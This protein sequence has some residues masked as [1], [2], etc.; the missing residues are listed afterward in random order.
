MTQKNIFS[1]F[2][3]ILSCMFSQAY[4]QTVE[5]LSLSKF[6]TEKPPKSI[7][8]KL[9]EPLEISEDVIFQAGVIMQGDLYNVVSPKRLKRDA[10]FSFKPI[11][12]QG[13]DGKKYK[14][15]SNIVASYTEPLNKGELAKNAALGVGNFFV[16]GLSMGVAAVS[17]AVKNQEG[18]R[19][20]SSAVSVYES[21]PLSYAEKGQDISIDVNQ[22][23]YLKFSSKN[24]KGD[25]NV[26]S[27]S[28]DEVKGQNY[29]YNIIEKE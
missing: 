24:K 12:Y 6:S 19:I 10:D 7:T 20:K 17:G 23:F 22:P 21:S 3:I 28:T 13:L 11:T 9:L 8:V 14:V 18:N 15:D 27:N 5:V 16:K 25:D 1:V 4:G 26:E 29:S 2:I